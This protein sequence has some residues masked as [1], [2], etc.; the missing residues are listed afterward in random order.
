[1]LSLTCKFGASAILAFLVASTSAADGCGE[2]YSRCSPKGATSTDTPAVGTDLATLYTNL[3]NSVNGPKKSKRGAREGRDEVDVALESRATASNLCCVAG[4]QCLL[5]QGLNEPFCYDNYTTNFFLPGGAYGQI[6]SGEYNGTN[7]RANL[8][9]GNFTLDDGTTGNIYGS[10]ES[11]DRPN[12]STLP[13][14][15]QYTAA[16]SGSAIAATALGQVL[17]I[18][19]TIPG[20][21]VEPSTVSPETLAPSV[22]G[23]STVA[24]G[25]VKPGTTIPGSTV[26]AKTTTYTTTAAA[27]TST[28]QGEAGTLAPVAGTAAGFGFLVFAIFGL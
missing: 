20:T 4:T 16:G 3:L 5:L 13:I 15:T 9:G 8:V 14:P 18:T 27:G 1:M 22:S 25:T 26:A 2:N 21:T 24:P 7:G 10:P 11:P 12:T 19:T 17:T 23:T 28:A 6:V